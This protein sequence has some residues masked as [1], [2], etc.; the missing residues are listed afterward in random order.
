VTPTTATTTATTTP[1]TTAISLPARTLRKVIIRIVPFV[2]AMYF[3]NYLDRTNLGI[4]NSDISQHLQL[5]ATM[6]GLA[7]GIFF[8]GYV[9]VEVPS[10]LALNRRC[11]SCG[12][13]LE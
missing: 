2:M 8:I 6:F 1:T 9:L 10:N 7:S 13:C 5:S 12:S 3:V 11:W 4:A